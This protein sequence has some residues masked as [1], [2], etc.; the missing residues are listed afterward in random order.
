[1]AGSGGGAGT[2]QT[3]PPA[4]MASSLSLLLLGK[5]AIGN[6]SAA[7]EIATDAESALRFI[8]ENGLTSQ[9]GNPYEGVSA[10]NA[11][12]KLEE[13]K[14]RLDLYLS[15]V[16]ALTPMADWNTYLTEAVADEN[17]T[18]AAVDIDAVLDDIITRALSKV[19]ASLTQ[20]A[21]DALTQT[22]DVTTD[23]AGES[24][25]LI[26][27]AAAIT[28]AEAQDSIQLGK[29]TADEVIPAMETIVSAEATD[30]VEA[31][32]AV[33]DALIP[34]METV[35][36]AEATDMAEAAQAVSDALIPAIE[37]IA[38]VQAADVI[39][40]GTASINT[41]M[42][43]IETVIGTETQDLITK[44]I[45]AAQSAVNNAVVV[46]MVAAYENRAL[47]QHLRGVNRFVG[48]MADINAVNS[49]AFIIGMALLEVEFSRNVND[50]QTKLEGDLY[51]KAFD[52]FLD[53]G[54]AN[55]SL[56]STSLGQYTQMDNAFIDAHLQS[57]GQFTQL[58]AA[59]MNAY[60]NA[61]GHFAQLANANIGAYINTI[62]TL[63]D[64]TKAYM[65]QWVSVMTTR[66][67]LYRD[68]LLEYGREYTS[69][70]AE[71]MRGT[72]TTRQFLQDD[73]KTI[74]GLHSDELERHHAVTALTTEIGRIHIVAKSEEFASN[75]EYDTKSANW[76]MELFQMGGNLVS[77]YSGGNIGI[78]GKPSRA[79]S[80]IGGGLSGV[81][82]GIG[83]GVAMGATLG[84]HGAVIGGAVGG[85]AGLIA[86][87]Q[88]G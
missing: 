23:G 74:A 61:L 13:I 32:Q 9:G 1:M 70:I 38:S 48:G 10:Y 41:L 57:T 52:G 34:A 5:G 36:S 45:T 71:H 47:T 46:A 7:F 84:P 60:M 14:E 2:S 30:M 59:N 8:F 17:S 63:A 19:T 22:A 4:F 73:L 76:D 49:S 58:A 65:T 26:P 66:V 51:N 37:A 42:A 24:D 53:V 85:I 35:V 31:G 6:E 44:A 39:V 25:V 88:G 67:G 27:Q 50:F 69:Y 40:A 21:T 20:A 12:E 75:L 54:K 72:L 86:G 64:L 15:K 29:T 16:D 83:A 77:A 43:A 79:Q 62:N 55:M 3:I 33:V 82:A 78:A 80:M 87:Y 11:D 56:Y 81:S 18:I 28:D 68:A